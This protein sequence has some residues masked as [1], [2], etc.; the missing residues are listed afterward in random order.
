[1][2]DCR[3]R[4]RRTHTD[5]SGL[6]ARR[7]DCGAARGHVH[8]KCVCCVF[9]SARVLLCGSRSDLH[10]RVG[11]DAAVTTCQPGRGPCVPHRSHKAQCGATVRSKPTGQGRMAATLHIRSQ[12]MGVVLVGLTLPV[13]RLSP[14]T[15]PESCCMCVCRYKIYESKKKS[16]VDILFRPWNTLKKWFYDLDLI[17]KMGI[18]TASVKTVYIPKFSH[19]IIKSTTRCCSFVTNVL[20][21]I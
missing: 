13:S 6:T 15:G 16:L 2:H 9:C 1:M 14:T 12:K 5:P 10:T 18:S 3:L 7:G 8:V 19:I 11:A 21:S 17:R 20:P 4:D